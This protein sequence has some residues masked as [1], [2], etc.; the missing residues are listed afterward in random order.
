MVEL[1]KAL[2]NFEAG[3]LVLRG[4]LGTSWGRLLENWA[5]KQALFFSKLVKNLQNWGDFMDQLLGQTW[6]NGP[7]I[8]SNFQKN[9]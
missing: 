5:W 7:I 9:L 6:A 2:G 3:L 4:I 8:W 1:G